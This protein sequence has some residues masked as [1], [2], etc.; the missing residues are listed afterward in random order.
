MGFDYACDIEIEMRGLFAMQIFG[1]IHNQNEA[2][3]A[4]ARYIQLL[5]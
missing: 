5:K 2:P 3:E 1:S 4:R